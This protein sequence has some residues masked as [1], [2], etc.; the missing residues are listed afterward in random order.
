MHTLAAAAYSW[1]L[2]KLAHIIYTFFTFDD[3][4]LKNRTQASLIRDGLAE[5]LTETTL[6]KSDVILSFTIEIVIME[7]R[8]L[9]SLQPN[10]NVYCT[11]EVEGSEKLQT[12]HAPASKAQ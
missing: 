2:T 3:I 4:I 8:G 12:E 7:I 9:K 6:S 11:M 10:R 1:I 5:D